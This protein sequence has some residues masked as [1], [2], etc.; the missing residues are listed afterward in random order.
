MNN[1]KMFV[2]AVLMIFAAAVSRVIT[3]PL[4]FS[5]MIAMALFAGSM[6]NNKKWAFLLPLAAMLTSDLLFEISGIAPGFWGVGQ[7]VNYALLGLIT[8]LGMFMNKPS[9]LKVAGFSVSSSVIFYFFSNTAVWMFDGMYANTLSGWT[10]CMASG[11]PFLY[12]GV[13][14]DLMFCGVLFGGYALIQKAFSQK[15]IA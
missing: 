13:F 5:P 2:V 7:V 10:L 12:K 8:V 11:L 9:V 4:S 14:I 3:F 1:S 15:A 6:V